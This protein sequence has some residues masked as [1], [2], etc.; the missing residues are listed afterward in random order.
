MHTL[1]NVGM[2]GRIVRII[3]KPDVA[4]TVASKNTWPAV[5]RR[6]DRHLEEEGIEDQDQARL[7]DI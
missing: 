7:Q 1:V 2:I 5:L 3:E 4:S 6:I